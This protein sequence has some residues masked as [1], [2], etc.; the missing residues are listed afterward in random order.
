M[1]R[2]IGK[3]EVL[4]FIAL[5][6]LG[7]GILWPYIFG[8]RVESRSNLCDFRLTQLGF[9]I[10]RAEANANRIPNYRNLWQPRQTIESQGVQQNRI[11]G[12]PLLALPSL[13]LEPQVEVEGYAIESDDRP[14]EYKKLFDSFVLDYSDTAQTELRNTYLPQL[15]CPDNP[16]VEL[17]QGKTLPG[18]Y[19]SFVANG[20]L[21]DVQHMNTS[22]V[23]VDYPANGLF[24]DDPYLSGDQVDWN[25]HTFQSVSDRDGLDHTLML[26]ENVD[27]G[28]W[29]DG[30]P[31]D[32]LFHWSPVDPLPKEVAVTA[33]LGINEQR[34]MGRGKNDIRYARISSHHYGTANV[35]YASGR[36]DKL[37][38]SI[39][40]RVLQLLMMSCDEQGIWPGT[41]IPILSSASIT[42][43]KD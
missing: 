12:W 42:T 39:S 31:A 41:N 14:G 17:D 16:P 18:G 32:L 22:A 29:L 35:V 9:S 27:S 43:A 40:P 23:L 24:T 11:V 20:G 26:S 37:H 8:R 19:T 15:V 34:G 13:G 28:N 30:R 6:I 1:K 25:E 10:Q 36:T 33:V 5:A 3:S 4:A 38:E 21:P 7:G 2:G